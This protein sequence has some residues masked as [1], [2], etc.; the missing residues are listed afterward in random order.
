[1]WKTLKK[2]VFKG[3]TSQKDKDKADSK[4]SKKRK[5]GDPKKESKSTTISRSANID[6]PKNRVNDTS[7]KSSTKLAP[8]SVNF[9]SKVSKWKWDLEGIDLDRSLSLFYA[10]YN[11]DKVD[12]VHVILEEFRGEEGDLLNELCEL[13]DVSDTDMQRFLDRGKG[14]KKH[15]KQEVEVE[16]K[17]SNVEDDHLVESAGEREREKS[18]RKSHRMSRHVQMKEDFMVENEEPKEEPPPPS[19][20]HR[21]RKQKNGSSTPTSTT[22]SMSSSQSN[23]GDMVSQDPLHDDNDDNFNQGNL[24]ASVAAIKKM[25][26]VRLVVPGLTDDTN[27]TVE[28]SGLGQLPAWVL[29]DREAAALSTSH[30][31]SNTRIMDEADTEKPERSKSFAPPPNKFAL[32]MED[33]QK[34]RLKTS[35]ETDSQAQ[36]S[37]KGS[38]PHRPSETITSLGVKKWQPVEEEDN[39]EEQLRKWD[40]KVDIDQRIAHHSQIMTQSQQV[41]NDD[42]NQTSSGS[43]AVKTFDLLAE[44][45][46]RQAANKEKKDNQTSAGSNDSP[47]P[48]GLSLMQVCLEYFVTASKPTITQ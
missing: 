28:G 45:R 41:A 14:H 17:R 21:N 1:M 3:S 8:K 32:L 22:M 4:D 5:D 47:K 12:N 11:P 38:L 6:T 19:K 25:G 44:I 23:M 27:M 29:R 24:R 40:E 2:F 13:Y 15:G 42:E 48:A 9:D 18:R 43:S 31:N 26:G 16:R 20:Y 7:S 46:N 30:G 35:K 34:S 10:V 37:G 36:E 39:I 33:I